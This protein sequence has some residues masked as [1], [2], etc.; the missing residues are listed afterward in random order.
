MGVVDRS[1]LRHAELTV[2]RQHGAILSAELDGK[3]VGG[4]G[5]FGVFGVDC[6]QRSAV[7]RR[8]S[9]RLRAQRIVDFPQREVVEGVTFH[10]R[11]RAG[12]GVVDRSALRHAELAVIRQLGAVLSAEL[13]GKGV[14]IGDLRLGVRLGRH[15]FF[16]KVDGDNDI[17]PLYQRSTIFNRPRVADTITIRNSIVFKHIIIRRRLKIRGISG[18]VC[19]QSILKLH[20]RKVCCGHF[21]A[22]I[23]F[24]EC[25][26]INVTFRKRVQRQAADRHK[27]RDQH[28]Q[29][30]VQTTRFLHIITPFFKIL[31]Q[32]TGRYPPCDRVHARNPLHPAGHPPTGQRAGSSG[33]AWTCTSSASA[34]SPSR[35]GRAIT[36]MRASSIS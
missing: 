12:M 34:R 16:L 21:I 18:I 11:P 27:D 35:R 7:I 1:A 8:G 20:I 26:R 25:E 13:D 10:D 6:V 9:N 22:T 30:A 5:R 28:G 36:S 14:G 4:G 24:D 15:V 17:A 3:G 31:F 23:L 29:Q 2:I 32:S 33:S 19:D